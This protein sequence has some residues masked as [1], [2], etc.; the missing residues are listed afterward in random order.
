M[1]RESD[2][3]SFRKIGFNFFSND[4]KVTKETVY[5]LVIDPLRQLEEK[6]E[7]INA[8]RNENSYLEAST[9]LKVSRKQIDIII[10]NSQTDLTAGSNSNDSQT[11][12]KMEESKTSFKYP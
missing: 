2:G 11:S 4:D 10:N 1:A 3:P 7:K 8:M 12:N 5:S 9:F 6:L